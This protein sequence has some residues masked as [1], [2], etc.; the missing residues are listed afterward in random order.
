[1]PGLE[2]RGPFLLLFA[3][4]QQLGSLLSRAMTAAPLTPAEF[5]VYSALR[6]E[7][8]TTPSELAH[9]LGMRA[10]TM[11]SHLVKMAGL[12]HLE[13]ARNP[14]DGRSRLISLT[15]AGMV[16]TE[17]CFPGFERAISAFQASL[18]V[19]QGDV[20]EV[21]EAVSAALASA[22]ASLGD[23]SPELR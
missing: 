19:D 8:P 15:P 11:S 7:Q 18:A 5:A 2:F 22:S 9:T 1:V 14:A 3:L 12:G 23:E 21:L 4:D 20:L 13:R 16:A 17:A 6:L 10:T